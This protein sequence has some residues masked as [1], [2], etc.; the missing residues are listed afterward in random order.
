MTLKI[1]NTLTREKTTFQPIKKN[2]VSLYACG[3]TVYDYCHLGHAR[4]YTFVDMIV[5]Y[6]TFL[7][8]NVNYVRNITDI[9]DK[10]IKH[11]QEKQVDF[12]LIVKQFTDAMHD[13]FNALQLL[14]PT[15]EP[16]ATDYIP[17][18]VRLIQTM[19]ERNHAYVASNGD[20]YFR[21]RSLG[22]YGMLSHHDLDQLESGARVDIV[23]VKEDP[24]DF[25]L[26]KLA[27]PNEPHWP[28]P[29]GEGRPGWH[30]ECTAMSIDLLGERFDIHTGARD[31]IFPHHE[32]ELAQANAVSEAGFA[33]NWMHMGFL[34]M[35]QEKMSKS[36]GNVVTIREALKTHDA[37]VLRFLFLASHYR[38]PLM[39]SEE[40]MQQAKQALSRF[41]TALRF[42]P[43]APLEKKTSYEEAFHDAMNDDFNTPVAFSVLFDLTHEIQ[44]QRDKDPQLAARLAAL[45]KYLGGILGLLNQ[46]PDAFFQLGHE[47][48]VEKIESLIKARDLARFEKNWAKADDIRKELLSLS[49]IIEDGAEGSTWRRA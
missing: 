2:D 29:F 30:T 32:N 12:A 9:D 11:A 34:T 26:W 17:H 47:M 28:S 44:R 21:I 3:V 37:E 19:L 23:D 39:Y 43:E 31:L 27:K 24:L 41:Y 48:D 16:R 14:L 25:V 15:H 7:G 45:L 18:M 4:T 20:V 35:A 8:F 13:D 46:S 49:V 33:A 10:I 5:R 36:L 42:L 40:G 38:S 6:L 22:N 1:Y